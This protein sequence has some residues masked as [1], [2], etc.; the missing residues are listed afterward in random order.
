MK[1][2]SK[3]QL[4]IGTRIQFIKELSCGPTEETPG[5]LYATKYSFGTVTGHDCWE[6]HM[7]LWDGWKSASFGAKLGEDFIAKNPTPKR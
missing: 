7:V 3:E 1:K 4:P 2:E 6:G 5:F